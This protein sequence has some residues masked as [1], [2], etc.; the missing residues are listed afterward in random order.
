MLTKTQIGNQFQKS[1]H[2]SQVVLGEVAE[3]LGYDREEAL[4]MA[5]P[6]G[7][8]MFRGDTCGAVTGA[9]IAIG[10]KYGHFQPGDQEQDALCREKVAEFQQ[11]FME[12]HGTT[13]CRELISYDFS[14]PGAF[15]RAAESGVFLEVCPAFVADALEILE[16]LL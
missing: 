4:R 11:R 2:C 3:E 5:A 8:G 14:Q 1:I 16:D 15:A 6:F 9:M 7:A 13:I 12:K 10:M